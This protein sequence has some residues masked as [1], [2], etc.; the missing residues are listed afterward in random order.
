MRTPAI[1]I[2]VLCLAGAEPSFTLKDQYGNEKTIGAP[3]PEWTLVIYGDRVGGDYSSIWGKGLKGKA[4][5]HCRIAFAANLRSVPFFLKGM[6]TNKFLGKGADG[7]N[8]GPVLLD[9]EGQIARAFGHTPSVANVYAFDPSGKMRA[10]DAGKGGEVEVDRF[11]AAVLSLI[12]PP[13][14]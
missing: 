10:K 3:S 8:K 5:P 11:A 7:K 13:V 6:M 14:P 12:E 4:L 9:W 2:S 1:W